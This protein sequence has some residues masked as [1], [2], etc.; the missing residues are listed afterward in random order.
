MCGILESSTGY[1]WTHENEAQRKDCAGCLY[2]LGVQ[3]PPR[4]VLRV[5]KI[6]IA[7]FRSSIVEIRLTEVI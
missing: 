3:H 5:G 4:S 2:W 1:F 7:K 6:C